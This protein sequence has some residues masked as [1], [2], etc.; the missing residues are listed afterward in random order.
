[1]KCKYLKLRLTFNDLFYRA[2]GPTGPQGAQGPTGAQGVQGI[3]GPTGPQGPQGPQG[4]QGPT[5][6][7]G[8]TG[9]QGE[10][11]EPLVTAYS[12][13]Y[14]QNT[15]SYTLTAN[16]VTPVTLSTSGP[17][18]NVINT[19]PNK[20][21]IS[22]AGVYKIDYFFLGTSNAATVLTLQVR[23]NDTEILKM[24]MLMY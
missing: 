13:K 24:L 5:G 4:I 2:T 17:N 23:K 9:P 1:M 11:A 12:S 15:Q 10:A 6:P 3:E 21:T 8:P 20:L 14:Q 7:T 16:T 19:T 18:G 22:E